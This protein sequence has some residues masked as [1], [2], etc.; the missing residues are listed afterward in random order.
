MNKTLS[1]YGKGYIIHLPK[2][3]DLTFKNNYRGITHTYIA[4]KLSNLM[5]LNRLRPQ[6]DQILRIN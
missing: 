4:A 1:I 3:G 6:V 2:K 5:I